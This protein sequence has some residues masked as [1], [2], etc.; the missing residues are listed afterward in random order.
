M[1]EGAAPRL[2]AATRVARP[3]LTDGGVRQLVAVLL[4]AVL[5]ETLLLRLVTRIGVHVPKGEGV[6]DAFQAASFLGSLAFNFASLLAIVLVVLVLVAL[7]QRTN[8][9][10]GRLALALLSMA[11]LSG[12]GLTLATGAPAADALF[13]VAVALLVGL[14]GLG[15]AGREGTRLGARLALVLMVAAYFSYQ[16][17]VLAHLFYRILDYGAVPPLTIEVLRLGEVLT[18]AAAAVAFWAWGLPR[19]RWVGAAGLAGVAAVLFALTL[20]GL[21]PVSTMAILALWTTG[22]SL[23]LP[24]PIYLV[25]LALYLLT[26]VAC[27]RS[28]DGFWIGAG[29]LLILL[30]GYMPEATYQHLLLLLGVAF[31][32]RAVEWSVLSSGATESARTR[33]SSPTR[34]QVSKTAG[35]GFE[36]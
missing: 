21:S 26:L 18:V 25:A 27:W 33:P 32:S 14:M 1:L 11:M 29:L 23:F 31:L 34:S 3:A 35:R 19:W 22:L 36:S 15:L 20:A 8:S 28:G 6:A 30:A 16:Y 9:G 5:A 17:Y 10:V 4:A 2:T 13:G 24:F 12:L 7:V